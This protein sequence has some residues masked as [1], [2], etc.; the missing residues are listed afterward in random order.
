MLHPMF[1]QIFCKKFLTIILALKSHKSEQAI[2]ASL[3][4][5]IPSIDN[6]FMDDYVVLI[7]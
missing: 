7:M 4:V 1:K 3:I 5:Y 6:I 2:K